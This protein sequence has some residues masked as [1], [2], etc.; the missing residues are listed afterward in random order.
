MLS[1]ERQG[2]SVLVSGD[3]V[4]EGEDGEED[5]EVVKEN[6]DGARRRKGE[7]GARKEHEYLPRGRPAAS[8]MDARTGGR[9][10]LGG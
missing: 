6:G 4:R 7:M 8:G 3:G 1:D 9:T 10:E 5:C 2:D